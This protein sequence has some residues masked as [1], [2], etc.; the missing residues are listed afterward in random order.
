MTFIKTIPED[1]A[2]GVTAVMYERNRVNSGYVPNFV[3]AF[4]HKPAVM[5]CFDALLDSIKQ[6]MDPRR[7]EL[8]T[9]AAAKEM[10]CSYCMLAHG[11]VLKR[12]FFS[13]EELQT[14]ADNP[15][16]S[17]LDEADKSVMAFAAKVV[18]DATSVTGDDVENLRKHGLSETDIFDVVTAA[19]VRCFIGKTT[20]A[21]GALPD[22]KFRALEPELLNVLV[23]GRPISD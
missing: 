6:H 20:D 13:A 5:D 17:A 10:K 9:I 3:K 23:V 7:Y 19:A 12:D 18:R 21:L 15:S 8:V 2:E 14:I 16:R 22:S 11:S 1:R 4:S